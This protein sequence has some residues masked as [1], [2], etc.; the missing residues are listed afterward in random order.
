MWASEG[1][2]ITIYWI[3]L[4]LSCMTWLLAF[5]HKKINKCVL[6]NQNTESSLQRKKEKKKTFWK[7][8]FSKLCDTYQNSSSCGLWSL[9]GLCRYSWVCHC[10]KHT[11][12]L[13]WVHAHCCHQLFACISTWFLLKRQSMYFV[14][15]WEKHKGVIILAF[16]TWLQ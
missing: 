5:Q 14:E 1:R 9:V 10:T 13:N 3:E 16:L 15:V 12:T 7:I 2:I 11:C 6:A 8:P 4:T